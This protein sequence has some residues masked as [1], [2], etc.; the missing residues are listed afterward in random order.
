M[1]PAADPVLPTGAPQ[2]YTVTPH[3]YESQ[4]KLMTAASRESLMISRQRQLTSIVLMTTK[5]AVDILQC[6]GSRAA[7]NLRLHLKDFSCYWIAFWCH[8]INSAS[9]GGKAVLVLPLATC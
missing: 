7:Y 6:A 9:V 2:P 1:T 4:F 5:E 8:W 3:C